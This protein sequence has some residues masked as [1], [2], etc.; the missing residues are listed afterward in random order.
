MRKPTSPPAATWP[1]APSEDRRHEQPFHTS[2]S[3]L[4]PCSSWLL[5]AYASTRPDEFRV[6]RRARIA[7]PADKVWPLISELRA[8]NRLEPL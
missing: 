8:F 7:A 6:E 2:S 5:L 3:A 1:S 4:A